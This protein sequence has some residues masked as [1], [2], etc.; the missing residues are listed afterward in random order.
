MF[1]V[2]SISFHRHVQR[3]TRAIVTAFH[4]NAPTH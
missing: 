4:H 1:I 3:A 2:I